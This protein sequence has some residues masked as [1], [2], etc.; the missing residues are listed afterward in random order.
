M[1]EIISTFCAPSSIMDIAESVNHENI[2]V[3]REKSQVS[4]KRGNA[5]PWIPMQNTRNEIDPVSSA[6]RN[7]DISKRRVFLNI[8]E[9]VSATTAIDELV[10][11]LNN[12]KHR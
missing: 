11:F 6:E 9:D 2:D 8:F 1:E 4:G 7:N 5:V 10:R 3:R 12:C